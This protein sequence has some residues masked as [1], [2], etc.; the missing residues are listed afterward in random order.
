M[1]RSVLCL[2]LF[3]LSAAAFGCTKTK[4]TRAPNGVLRLDCP[5]G[6]RDCVAQAE[7]YCN[8]QD[9]MAGYAIMS[10]TS[11][12]ITMGSKDGQYRTASEVA[13]LEVRCGA[14]A[15]LPS[16]PAED[17][18][19]KLPPRSDAPV[20]AAVAGA[21]VAAPS[22]P[23]AGACTK[24]ATQTCVGPGACQGGQVCLADGSGF[25]SCDCGTVPPASAPKGP[26]LAQ[27]TAPPQA[28]AVDSTSGATPLAK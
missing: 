27:P 8:V 5:R 14:E 24:G 11:R 23:V 16:A 9:K 2:C 12:K 19:Y 13:E 1:K 15:E 6:M 18:A 10:G 28:P 4:V 22:A 3:A 20:E 21:V 17:S 7:K 25:G 26:S